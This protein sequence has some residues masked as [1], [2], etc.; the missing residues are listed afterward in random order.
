MIDALQTEKYASQIAEPDFDTAS[1]EPLIGH[2]D[3]GDIEA[4]LDRA[5]QIARE[6]AASCFTEASALKHLS[7]IAHASGM[8]DGGKPVEWLQEHGLIEK[9]DGHWRFKAAKPETVDL[10]DGD[11][12]F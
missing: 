4:V 8:P 9:A 6:Q 2:L 7:R 11:I 3:R 12:P 1:I 10:D 5:E